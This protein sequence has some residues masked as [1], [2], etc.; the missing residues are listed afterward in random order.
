MI[1][2]QR[3]NPADSAMTCRIGAPDSGEA[4]V[5]ATPATRRAA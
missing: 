4:V 2:R 3:F 1:F 5:I